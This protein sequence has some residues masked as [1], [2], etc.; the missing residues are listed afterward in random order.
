MSNFANELLESFITSFE[1][2]KTDGSKLTCY[3][4]DI[5]AGDVLDF[6]HVEE[7][8]ERNEALL[9]LISLAI[10]DEDGEQIFKGTGMKQ[11]RKMPV[12]IFEQLS[13]AVVEAA[14]LNTTE[15]DEGN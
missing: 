8:P 9:R 15:E 5:C 3:Q 14:G 10:V 12:K 1:V 4:Q 6:V 13:N 11:L 2:T 7:G